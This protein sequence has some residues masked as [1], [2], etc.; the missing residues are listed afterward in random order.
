MVI[1]RACVHET[2]GNPGPALQPVSFH[3]ACMEGHA[4]EKEIRARDALRDMFGEEICGFPVLIVVPG[5][6]RVKRNCVKN[7]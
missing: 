6:E 5:R 3:T 1:C 7:P 2:A 4:R